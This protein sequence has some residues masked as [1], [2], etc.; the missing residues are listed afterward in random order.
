MILQWLGILA[1]HNKARHRK[2]RYINLSS[3]TESTV[4][5][6]VVTTLGCL[7]IP[8]TYNV[9]INYYSTVVMTL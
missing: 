2:I 6:A 5:S 3:A 1:Y 8:A 4:L 7:S 9:Y